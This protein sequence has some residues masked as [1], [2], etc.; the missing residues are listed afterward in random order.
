MVKRTEHTPTG[1]IFIFSA[2]S[3]TG[4]TTLAGIVA[5]KIPSIRVAVSHTTRPPRRGERDGKEYYFVTTEKFREMER[6]G[7]FLES[8]R[9]HGHLYG[10]SAEEVSLCRESG[11]DVILDIDVQGAAEVQKKIEAVS[12]FILPPDMAQLRERL[13]RRN[14]EGVEDQKK[15]IENAKIE[16]QAVYSFDYVVVNH[17]VRDAVS[18]ISAIITSERLRVERNRRFLEEFIDKNENEF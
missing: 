17:T 8:A 15:R 12:I 6:A 1:I 7:L 16:I 10:T 18:D 9:V 5:K 13:K 4:K 2:P 11:D 14:T 3:G